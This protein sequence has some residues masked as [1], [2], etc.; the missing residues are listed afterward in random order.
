MNAAVYIAT[1]LLIVIGIVLI[2]LT[3]TK[4]SNF[5][6]IL[7]SILVFLGIF[8]TSCLALFILKD[9]SSLV[10]VGIVLISIILIYLVLKK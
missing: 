4:K 9:I 5:S 6:L 7:G 1:L 8:G 3:K 10:F 2:N